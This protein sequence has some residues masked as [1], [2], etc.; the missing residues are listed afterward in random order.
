MFGKK[1]PS[2]ASR[3]ELAFQFS[4]LRVGAWGVRI[5]A[6][7]KPQG[8]EEAWPRS[9]GEE[10][11]RSELE[12]RSPGSHTPAS[13]DTGGVS[14]RQLG[15]YHWPNCSHFYS[16]PDEVSDVELLLK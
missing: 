13:C 6:R 16:Y 12:A 15:L 3:R 7:P 5:P 14:L 2:S 4:V 8:G 11:A 10:M 9:L 1:T